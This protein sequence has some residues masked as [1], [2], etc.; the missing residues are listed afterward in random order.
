MPEKEGPG[1]PAQPPP[2]G[3]EKQCSNEPTRIPTLVCGIPRL[4]KPN[5]G[6]EKV[7]SAERA[8]KSIREKRENQ[9]YAT[10]AVQ[11]SCQQI[12]AAATDGK[13][14]VLPRAGEECCAREETRR[15]PRGRNGQNGSLERENAGRPQG[16]DHKTENEQQ[17][18]ESKNQKFQDGCYLSI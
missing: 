4:S 11:Q 5:D 2:R 15:K 14:K 7:G 3:T 9:L 6:S 13:N 1:A 10:S 18:A 12:V 17:N 16:R 8:T